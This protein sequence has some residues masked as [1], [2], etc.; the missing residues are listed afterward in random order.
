MEVLVVV[1]VISTLRVVVDHH[2]RQLQ[3]GSVRD[4]RKTPRVQGEAESGSDSG[5]SKPALVDHSDSEP[6][7]DE[8]AD[9]DGGNKPRMAG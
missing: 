9:E 1:V 6:D 3:G 5:L 7:S 4:A 8:D 2:T